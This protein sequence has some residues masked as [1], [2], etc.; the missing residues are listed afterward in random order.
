MLQNLLPVIVA[1]ITPLVLLSCASSEL[2]NDSTHS[3]PVPIV[4]SCVVPEEVPD[5]LNMTDSSGMRETATTH[6]GKVLYRFN[7]EYGWFSCLEQFLDGTFDP[8]TSAL[9][10]DPRLGFSIDG[11]LGVVTK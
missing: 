5:V 6:P 4:Y 1:L 7:H 9:P 8:F 2:S 3:F 11:R 10:D